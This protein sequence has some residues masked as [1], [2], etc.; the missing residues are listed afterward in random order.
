MH[1]QVD[2]AKTGSLEDDYGICLK[3]LRP[4]ALLHKS[5]DPKDLAL[6]YFC[7]FSIGMN[8]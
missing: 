5:P 1:V 2:G 4:A 8:G 3:S 6:M 7:Q